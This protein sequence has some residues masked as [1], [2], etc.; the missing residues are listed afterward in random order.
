MVYVLPLSF[1]ISLDL[2]PCESCE[3]FIRVDCSIFDFFLVSLCFLFLSIL[4]R[5]T[6]TISI[7]FRIHAPFTYIRQL[8]ATCYS[9]NSMQIHGKHYIA[10]PVWQMKCCWIERWHWFRVQCT[11]FTALNN[12][13]IAQSAIATD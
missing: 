4:F 8:V 7:E 10:K 12:C 9:I 1:N 3:C 6:Q 2:P 13:V 5:S 11:P